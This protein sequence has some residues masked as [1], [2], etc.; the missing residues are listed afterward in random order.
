M[1]STTSRK[2]TH[3]PYKVL[4]VDDSPIVRSYINKVIIDVTEFDIIGQAENGKK[5]LELLQ[6][7]CKDTEVVILDIEMPVMDGISA[8]PEILKIKPSVK[9]IMASTLTL[10]NA[11]ISFEAMRLGASDYIPKPTSS[12]LLSNEDS[13]K[14]ELLG[15]LKIYGEKFRKEEVPQQKV[16]SAS[17]PK[18][19]KA[20][21]TKLKKP[22]AIAIGSSTGGPKALLTLLKEL[23]KSVSVPIFITQHMPE[24]FTKI[25]AQNIEQVV[26][27]KCAEAIDGETVK[28]NQI[29][30][31][32]G[33]YHLT[34]RREASGKIV[35]RL[36]QN[37][38]V[39]FCRPA[40][41][42]MLESLSDIYEDKLMTI[43]LTGMGQD[44]RK[45]CQKS[46]K[47]GG[48]IIAQDEQT[49]IVWGMPGSV[50]KEG[51]CD[52]ILPLE[53]ISPFITNVMK[54]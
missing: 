38:L 26:Q 28:D 32:P 2:Q 17:K 9:I 49:S 45:G 52:A 15:K 23:T 41:D 5:A 7:D 27:K 37:P 14:N 25:L 36:D 47:N 3:H 53:E 19:K 30:I 48:S 39:N 6:G 18:V 24:N 42:P 34:I 8:I 50:A 20:T 10:R 31:A 21:E 13:F 46:S 1:H 51:I 11:E 4:V 22:E 54:S 44:G 43:I 12:Q 29:Y 40:V 35:T 16:F 33:N